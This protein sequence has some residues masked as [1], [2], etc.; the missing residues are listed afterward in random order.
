MAE[1]MT[2]EEIE[3]DTE[4]RTT[5]IGLFHNAETYWQAAVALEKA[6]VRSTH[7]DS[8]IRFLYYHAIELYLK[9]LLRLHGHAVRELSS[10]KFG[11][12]IKTLTERAAQLGLTFETEDQMIFKLMGETDAVIRSRYHRT[13]AFYWPTLDG[14][15]RICDRLHRPIRDKLRNA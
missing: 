15:D 11:H 14:L 7:P 1:E 6:K 12:D 10:R 3:K 2:P 9:S 8:P 5:P 4:E 13:G